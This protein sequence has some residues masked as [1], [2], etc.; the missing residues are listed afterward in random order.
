MAKILNTQAIGG[1]ISKLVELPSN[2]IINGQFYKKTDLSPSPLDFGFYSTST[3]CE[4]IVNKVAFEGCNLAG[5]ITSGSVP[6]SSQSNISYSVKSGAYNNPDRYAYTTFFKTVKNGSDI[7]ITSY[8]WKCSAESSKSFGQ[9]VDQDE[10]YLYVV[11]MGEGYQS[12]I[13]RLDKN[14]MTASGTYNAGSDKYISIIRTN[15]SYVYA[16]ITGA[17]NY[18][19]VVKYNKIA[20]TATVIYDDTG[21]SGGY[22]SQCI[23]AHHPNDKNTFY[24]IRDGFMQN[25]LHRSVVKQY[26]LD[27]NTDTVGTT[28]VD[29][30]LSGYTQGVS[31]PT[32]DNSVE[33][34]NELYI[35]TDNGT[36]YLV[37]IRYGKSVSIANSSLLV[38]EFLDDTSIKLVQEVNF[39]PIKFTMSL[40]ANN[41]KTLLLANNGQVRFYSWNSVSKRYEHTSSV[42]KAIG[43]IGCDIDGNILIQY[44]DS[45]VDMFSTVMAIGVSANL[46]KEQYEYYGSDLTSNVIAYAQNFNGEFVATNARLTLIGPAVFTSTD[47][48][49][50][51]ITTSTVNPTIL[52][53]TIKDAGYVRVIIDLI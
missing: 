41:G 44:A 45:S 49:E 28:Y 15:D 43:L 2:Y 33:V 11:L 19:A 35:F 32:I 23:I 26:V 4:M 3:N 42:V 22:S 31:I 24:A 12:L 20:G 40:T 27:V 36:K 9:I 30:D 25:N 46:E 52:P 7:K 47:T 13:T 16:A 8:S 21:I 1:S 29:M 39:S 5:K 18:F 37:Y 38:F 51:E 14:T 53:I 10:K 6:D 34:M 17:N 48:A 50:I